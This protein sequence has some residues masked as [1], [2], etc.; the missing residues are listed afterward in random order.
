M[1]K[2]ILFALFPMLTVTLAAHQHESSPQQQPATETNSAPVYPLQLVSAWGATADNPLTTSIGSTHGGIVVGQDGKVYVSANKGIF[3][4]SQEGKLL[5]QIEGSA[6]GI[7]AMEIRQEG[8]K[9]FIYGAR[10]THA[11]IIKMQTDGSVVLRI[12]FPEESGIQGK[13]K[14]TSVAVKPNG[15]IL[16]ADGYGTNMI[17]EFDPAGK[18]LSAFGGKNDKNIEKFKTPHGISIDS[19]YNPAR[20]LIADREKRRLVHFDLDGKFIGEVFTGLRRPCAVSIF[21]GKV[22]IA[23]LQGRV[24]I[25]GKDNQLLGV[26]GDNPNQQQW[27]KFKIPSSDWKP[28]IFTAPHGLSWDSAGNLYV[29]DWNVEG[30]VSK[31]VP[32]K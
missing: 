20:I 24:T 30:R 10:N 15:N 11:E 6:A 26:V 14:P 27:A 4:F 31:W 28:G 29:Q 5:R 8:G 32:E 19:R 22:A 1:K 2:L 23:E 13:F 9:E 18:Y 16:I 17:F 7:H 12:P 21:D 25:L 3:V